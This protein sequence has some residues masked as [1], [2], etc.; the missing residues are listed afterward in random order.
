M[1]P[2]SIQ[3]GPFTCEACAVEFAPLE[4]G[5]CRRCRRTLCGRHLVEDVDA[6]GAPGG[7]HVC[8]AC[9][10]AASAG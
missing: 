2:H 8:D 1:L 7:S 5:I 4:G 6:Q 3:I 10:E 9:R